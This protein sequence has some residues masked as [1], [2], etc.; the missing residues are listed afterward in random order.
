MKSLVEALPE[1]NRRLLEALVMVFAIIA[2]NSKINKVI[3][4]QTSV[5]LFV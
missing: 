5:E 1:E 3:T 2:M 4:A